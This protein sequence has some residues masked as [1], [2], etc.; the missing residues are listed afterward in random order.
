MADTA[1]GTD[2]ATNGSGPTATAL[3]SGV[4]QR[5][6]RL[7]ELSSTDPHAAQ[8]DTWAWFAEVG[9][10]VTGG[11]RDDAMAELQELFATGR[12]STG[13]EGPTE[14]V[15]VAFTAHPAL[16]KTMAAITAAWLPWAGKTFD[17]EANR[18]RN[19][20]L[21][22]ARLPARLPWPT[23]SMGSEGDHL[24][25]FDFTTYVEPGALDPDVD[26]LVIDY[27]SVEDNPRVLIKSIRD[28]LVEI[29]PGAHLGKMLWTHRGGERHS[30]LAYFALKSGL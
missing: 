7:R 28:E 18:G 22:S 5:V 17:S 9:R 2:Q 15:L 24:A 20:L 13:I 10:R 4:G 6:E 16:D 26:V 23:Y 1:T 3:R 30:L 27:A 29:V 8:A 19:L 14:G 25:A 21:R 12:P 11:D